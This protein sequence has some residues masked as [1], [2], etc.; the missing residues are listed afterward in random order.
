MKLTDVVVGKRYVAK[1]SG[2]LQVVRVTELKEIP[3]A[4][5]SSRSAWRTL[6]YAV[7]ESSG[8]K[9]T[10]RSPQRLRSLVEG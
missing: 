9:L 7:N 10:I 2:R 1:V 3:P 8:R 4:S 6:I 5:W